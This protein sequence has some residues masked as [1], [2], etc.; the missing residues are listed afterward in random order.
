[1]ALMPYL[2]SIPL[3]VLR[4]QPGRL[5][6]RYVDLKRHHCRL[7]RSGILVCDPLLIILFAGGSFLAMIFPLHW[8]HLRRLVH[9]S[10][11][12]GKDYPD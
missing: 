1:M 4:A 3:G 6:F 12:R 2:I 11:R 8:A 9:N 10:P 7:R 5:E